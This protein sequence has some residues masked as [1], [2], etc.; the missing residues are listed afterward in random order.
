MRTEQLNKNFFNTAEAEGEFGPAYAPCIFIAGRS[1][2][3]LLVW[4]CCLVWWQ[5][6]YCFHLLSVSVMLGSL[7]SRVATV[8]ER[9][10]HSVNCTFILRLFEISVVSYFRGWDCGSD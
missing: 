3:V 8:W 4:L 7:S 6:I 9:D 5:V 10:T 1:K 2:V